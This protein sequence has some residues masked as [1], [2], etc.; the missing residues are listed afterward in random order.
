MLRNLAYVRKA[1]DLEHLFNGAHLLVVPWTDDEGA[2]PLLFSVLE[3]KLTLDTSPAVLVQLLY[4][5]CNLATGS[6]S[7]KSQVVD[8]GLVAIALRFMVRSFT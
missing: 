4:L 6:T 1:S 2:M 5:L 8:S 7:V 3:K